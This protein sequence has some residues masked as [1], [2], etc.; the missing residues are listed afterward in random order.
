MTR[1]LVAGLTSHLATGKTRLSRCVLLD[2][3]DGTALG[4]TDHDQDL[5]VSLGD[6]PSAL[7]RA[8]VGAIPSAASLSIGLDSDSFEVTGPIG[9]TVTRAAVKGGRYL[10]ARARLFDVNWSDTTQIARIMAGKVAEAKIEGGAFTFTV[11]SSTDALNQTIGRVLSPQCSNEFGVLSLPQSRCQAV[12]TVYEAEVIAVTD[13]LRFRVSWTSSPA[14]TA[15]TDVLGGKVEFT[16]GDLAGTLPVEVFSLSGSPL[17]TIETYQPLAEVPE[18]GDTLTV[19]EGCDKLR[20]TCKLKGQILNF[21]GFPD[22]VGTDA[23]VKFP[24]PGTS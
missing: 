16:S 11:R 3:R 5:T 8:D 4:I 22:V 21:S 9:S 7:F 12:P 10:R 13:D 2:L 20:A 19:E 15:A 17:D 23:Y 6:S 24:N 18:I 1:T 14:P